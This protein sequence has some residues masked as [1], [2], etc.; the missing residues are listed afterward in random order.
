[1]ENRIFTSQTLWNDI[2]IDSDGKSE[3]LLEINADGLRLSRIYFNGR[4]TEE[5]NVVKIFASVLTPPEIKEK[6]ALLVVGNIRD[7]IRENF[8]KHL[9][10]DLNLCV[11][12]I[13][14]YSSAITSDKTKYPDE[15]CYARRENAVNDLYDVPEDCRKT[16]WYEWIISSLYAVDFLFKNGLKKVSVLGIDSGANVLW[17]TIAVDKRVT[18]ACMING[19]GWEMYKG[20]FKYGEDSEPEFNESVYRY[21]SCYD[22]QTYAKQVQVPVMIVSETNNPNFDADRAVDTYLRLASKNSCS[23]YVVGSDCYLDEKAFENVETFIIQQ[24]AGQEV[25]KSF[26]P[27]IKTQAGKDGIVIKITNSDN[28]RVFASQGRI[29]PSS[30]YWEELFGDGEKYLYKKQGDSKYA[31]II[32]ETTLKGGLSIASGINAVKFD[33]DEK[34]ADEL[35]RIIYN[36]DDEFIPFIPE[37]KK[38]K[39]AYATLLDEEDKVV[40]KKGPFG[41][42]GITSQNGLKTYKVGLGKTKPDDEL[43]LMMDVYSECGATVTISYT[44]NVNMKNERRYS[45]AVKLHSSKVWEKVIVDIKKCF[46]KDHIALT[47]YKNIE[48]LTITYS[49]ECLFNNIL[50]I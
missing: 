31:F 44:E 12:G 1:M 7:P 24:F 25:E 45:C 37:L 32:A 9:A 38:E 17:K 42:Y 39:L 35:D 20:K 2:N 21:L 50:W 41:I 46:D 27:E 13:D 19:V 47:S 33:E 14:V 48:A 28:A 43:S 49:E 34:G 5:G 4:T 29:N 15:I 3:T 10:K 11:M 8:L 18:C 40:K 23:Y 22:A 36:S 30:R 16:C 6:N 26:L